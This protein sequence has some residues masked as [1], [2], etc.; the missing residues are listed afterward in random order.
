MPFELFG[1]P[2]LN[3]EDYTF[4][5]TPVERPGAR[6][7]K[8]KNEICQGYDLSQI[9][10]PDYIELEWLSEMYTAA[11]QVESFFSPFF[12]KL[13]GTDKLRKQLSQGL[14]TEAI[15]ASWKKDI[16]SFQGIRA[17]YLIYAE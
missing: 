6:R 5:F 11:N 16:E 13:A 7:P 10:A 4:S 2:G 1:R 14:D 15:R 3:T 12:D 17:K 9:K 8:F